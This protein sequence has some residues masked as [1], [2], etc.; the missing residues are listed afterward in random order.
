M[1]DCLRIV[2]HTLALVAF[3]VLLADAA[4]AQVASAASGDVAAA[5]HR[6]TLVLIAV[7]VFWKIFDLLK[8]AYDSQSEIERAYKNSIRSLK[9]VMENSEKTLSISL[10]RS[11]GE[12]ND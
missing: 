6:L 10:D 5:I 12:R 9:D 4:N 11:K 1:R 2:V 7:V 8:D 3:C